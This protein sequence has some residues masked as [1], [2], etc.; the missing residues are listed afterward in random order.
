MVRIFLERNLVNVMRL[1]VDP[2]DRPMI[3]LL[4]GPAKAA[5]IFESMFFDMRIF[6]SESSRVTHHTKGQSVMQSCDQH[7]ARGTVHLLPVA[8]AAPRSRAQQCSSL[9]LPIDVIAI[10]GISIQ[11]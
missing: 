6:A 3:P 1:A 11:H 4:R 7:F 2:S 8:T 9:A 10:R 5:R